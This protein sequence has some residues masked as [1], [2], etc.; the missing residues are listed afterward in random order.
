MQWLQQLDTQF[1]FIILSAFL[2]PILIIEGQMLKK[3]EGKL[4]NSA[5]FHFSSVLDTMWCF[6]S[7][8]ALYFIEFVPIAMSVP[9]A[10]IIYTVYGW[11]YGTRLLKK[12]GMPATVDDLVI[13]KAYIAYS[14]AFAMVFFALCMFVL[15][16]SFYINKLI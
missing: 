15:G 7:M 9:V 6:V 14:Q 2:S 13:P 5:W 1:I 10:Y 3:T 11:V 16:Y 12:E 8:A 4:P